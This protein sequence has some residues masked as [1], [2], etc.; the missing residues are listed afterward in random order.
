MYMYK[1][2]TYLYHLNIKIF[3]N[4]VY[5]RLGIPYTYRNHTIMKV[6][7]DNLFK[8]KT[9]CIKIM[10]FSNTTAVTTLCSV[11][12]LPIQIDFCSLYYIV[13]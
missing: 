4:V 5:Q 13:G 9:K 3:K 10:K 1:M 8:N 2:Y 6:V 7:N 11:K 12:Y